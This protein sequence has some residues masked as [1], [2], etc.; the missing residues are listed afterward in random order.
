ML[1]DKSIRQRQRRNHP[2]MQSL[3][4][5]IQD[6]V[7]HEIIT[8]DPYDEEQLIAQKLYKQF[9]QMEKNVTSV[10]DDY[11]FRNSMSRKLNRN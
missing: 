3:Q 10:P 9:R 11:A 5:V 4:G 1:L 2:W 8:D 7:R 6:W